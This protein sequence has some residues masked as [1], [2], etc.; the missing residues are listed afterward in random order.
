MNLIDKSYTLLKPRAII[1]DWDNTLVDSWDLIHESVNS[2]LVKY[3]KSPWS[4]EETK[5][6]IHKSNKNTLPEYF[7]DE[8]WKEVGE[9][10]RNC[11][12]NIKNRLKP[13]PDVENTLKAIADKKIHV[14]LVSNKFGPILKEEVQALRMDKYFKV[15]IGAG[16][17]KDDKPSPITVHAALIDTGLN[18]SDE[19]WFI[20]DTITDMETAYN[21]SCAP[22]LF[23]DSD[24]TDKSY[25]HCRPKVHFANHA[26]LSQYIIKF[27]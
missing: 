4:L 26:L 21:S 14:S 17:L 22:V 1:F 16:D 8:D 7:P 10:Y 12:I 20:G 2:T 18:P 25:D 6:K 13:L 11:Y 3:G 24:Y 9:F 5:L 27:L 23:G 15:V 19:V